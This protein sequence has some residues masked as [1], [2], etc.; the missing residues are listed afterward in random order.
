VVLKESDSERMDNAE[1]CIHTA[2]R[3]GFLTTR[4]RDIC[5]RILAEIEPTVVF[6]HRDF[7][8]KNVLI[9]RHF[10][11]EVAIVVDWGDAAWVSVGEEF[12]RMFHRMTGQFN[13]TNNYLID[14]YVRIAN[15]DRSLLMAHLRTFGVLRAFRF[16]KKGIEYDDASLVD[17]A[18]SYL[19]E[20][21]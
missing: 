5:L 21:V 6:A 4:Q 2:H 11:T 1:R 19:A 16:W 15:L 18:T 14:S 17:F 12:V 9:D 20:F 8:A 10:P 7:D 13:V 3:Y